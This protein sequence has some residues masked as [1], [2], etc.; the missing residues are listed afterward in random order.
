M[1]LI[2]FN[3]MANY[4]SCEFHNIAKMFYATVSINFFLRKLFVIKYILKQ[5][6]YT[7]ILYI[8]YTNIFIDSETEFSFKFITIESC[9]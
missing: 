3:V 9:S 6:Y 5:N 2:N 7:N 4:F 1:K 8:F